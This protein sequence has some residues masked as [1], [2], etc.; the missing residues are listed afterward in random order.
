ML[1]FM[2]LCIMH[3][4]LLFSKC[5]FIVCVHYECCMYSLF[6][7]AGVERKSKSL[8][9]FKSLDIR[10]NS[11]SNLRQ[12]NESYQ[13]GKCLFFTVVILVT[14]YIIYFICSLFNNAGSNSDCIAS[15]G[16]M[17]LKMGL[18]RMWNEPV[19]AYFGVPRH[20]PGGSDDSY[21]KFQSG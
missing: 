12:Q 1:K 20:F 19:I 16:W 15:A 7:S 10:Y 11:K 2:T 21:E 9:E 6:L 8:T 13:K 18:E 17:M 14:S 5:F 4:F 3:G